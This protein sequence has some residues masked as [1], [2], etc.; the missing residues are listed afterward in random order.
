MRERCTGS[1]DRFYN[2][3]SLYY[4]LSDNNET[5]HMVYTMYTIHLSLSITLHLYVGKYI[6]YYILLYYL[7]LQWCS[8]SHPMIKSYTMYYIVNNH[9]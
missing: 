2:F 6:E 8:M 5:I 9:E 7:E 4:H 3:Y 1:L